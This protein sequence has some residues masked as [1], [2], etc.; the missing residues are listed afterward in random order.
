MPARGVL[1]RAG[2]REPAEDLGSQ[3]PGI[4]ASTMPSTPA[5]RPS[6]CPQPKAVLGSRDEAPGVGPPSTQAAG[7]L[8]IEPRRRAS[9]AGRN[10][11]IR[12]LHGVS[13]CSLSGC[14]P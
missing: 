11:F 12:G 8:W 4:T 2:C 6:M 10:L 1:T 3:L 14:L 13:P 7:I 9:G 5:R